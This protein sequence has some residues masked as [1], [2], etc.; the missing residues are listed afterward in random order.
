MIRFLTTNDLSHVTLIPFV[1]IVRLYEPGR[2][3]KPS[4]F[5]STYRRYLVTHLYPF[6]VGH[7]CIWR[8]AELVKRYTLGK[9]WA[10]GGFILGD[11]QGVRCP[12]FY[13]MSLRYIN[14]PQ[15]AY[16]IDT[17]SKI[18]IQQVKETLALLTDHCVS[19]QNQ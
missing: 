10:P 11:L 3:R 12:S 14:V 7:H 16:R 6:C 4:S 5:S 2:H 18:H 8:G 9:A 17:E 15:K 19:F 13:N 1:K